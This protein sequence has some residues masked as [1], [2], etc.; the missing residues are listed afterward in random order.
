MFSFVLNIFFDLCLNELFFKITISVLIFLV[1]G[2]ISFKNVKF[3]DFFMTVSYTAF[4]GLFF[5]LLNF[6]L[7]DWYGKNW[8]CLILSI[9]NVFFMLLI[10]MDIN[11]KNVS[12]NGCENK[13]LM[14][15]EFV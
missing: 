8:I 3:S 7:K 5:F 13:K 6:L 11:V 2:C 15:E 9:V 4:R 10:N 12:A 14:E 1:L